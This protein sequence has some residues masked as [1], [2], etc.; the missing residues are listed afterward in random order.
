MSKNNLKRAIELAKDPNISTNRSEQKEF[1]KILNDPSFDFS[2]KTPINHTQI[3]GNMIATGG[4]G[5]WLSA[6]ESNNIWV[7]KK[8]INHSKV[9]TK[10]TDILGNN[11]MHICVIKNYVELAEVLLLHT[12]KDDGSILDQQ[13]LPK[14]DLD[15]SAVNSNRENPL[16]ISMDNNNLVI[17][18]LLANSNAID[19]NRDI[20]G[21]TPFIIA[22]SKGNLEWIKLM[23]ADAD[24]NYNSIS[25][26]HQLYNLGIRD[27]NN[28]VGKVIDFL[29]H[30]KNTEKPD[31]KVDINAKYNGDTLLQ[32]SI[33][34]Q[35][36]KLANYLI[37]QQE[38]DVNTPDSTQFSPLKLAM[39]AKHTIDRDAFIKALINHPNIDLYAQDDGQLTIVEKAYDKDDLSILKSL[40][41]IFLKNGDKTNHGTVENYIKDLENAGITV[42]T[43]YDMPP[44]N[45]FEIGITGSSSLC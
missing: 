30:Y 17:I 35:Q 8:L 25:I 38:I 14:I 34:D 39:D 37:Q 40:D 29:I 22:C 4:E 6:I 16:T 15:I 32:R 33:K 23:H 3:G 44:V 13:S 41:V 7:V 42:D 19:V 10:D 24:L 11:A 5:L 20:D 2:S 31:Q 45:D 27:K 36:F 21:K 18:T 43:A 12:R 26:L 9:N 28:K 1:V